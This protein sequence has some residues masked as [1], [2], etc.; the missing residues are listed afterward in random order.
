MGAPQS[1]GETTHNPHGLFNAEL[2]GNQRRGIDLFEGD[3]VN[4]GPV[5]ALV[6]AAIS[7]NETRAKK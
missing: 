5:Y 1:C 4:A 3:S 6:R 7:H 2:S